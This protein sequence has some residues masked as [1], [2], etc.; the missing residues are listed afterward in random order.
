MKARDHR[1]KERMHLMSL[2]YAIKHGLYDIA[3]RD[4]MWAF[5]QSTCADIKEKI[6]WKQSRE[7]RGLGPR[8]RPGLAKTKG[9]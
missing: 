3:F 5:Q 9:R 6:E 2:R 8:A 7:A 1:K 4:L